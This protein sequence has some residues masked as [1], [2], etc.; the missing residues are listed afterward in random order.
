MFEDANVLHIVI[1]RAYLKGREYRCWVTGREEGDN[2]PFPDG[3]GFPTPLIMGRIFGINFQSP[4]RRTDFWG[5]FLNNFCD[6]VFSAAGAI[7]G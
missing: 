6:C 4:T 7:F 1:P 5:H 2:P 3:G